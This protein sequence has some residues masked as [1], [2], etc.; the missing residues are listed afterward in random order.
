MTRNLSP[1]QR[2]ILRLIANGATA[3]EIAGS[4]QSREAT[5]RAHIRIILDRLRAR[6]QAQA[7]FLWF[8][9]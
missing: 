1:R 3:K 7:V 5:I 4:L 8:R 2:Q 9:S 6:T